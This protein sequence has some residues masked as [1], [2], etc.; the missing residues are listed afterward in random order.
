[1]NNYSELKQFLGSRSRK[2]LMNNTWAIDLGEDCVG[3]ELYH[4]TILKFC[5][6]DSIILNSGGWKTV[7]TK[8]RMN[9]YS[10]NF[11]V[12]QEKFVWYVHYFDIHYIYEDYMILNPDG[13]V[14]YLDR[15]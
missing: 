3:I 15:R 1:M 11:R 9:R 6:D 5:S 2:K 7:T 4:T 8:D 10:N 13:T 14:S 12:Y